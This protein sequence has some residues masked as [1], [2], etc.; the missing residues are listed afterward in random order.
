MNG[1][2]MPRQFDRIDDALKI[3]A[4]ARAVMIAI[5]EHWVHLQEVGIKPTEEEL[6][7][8]SHLVWHWRKAAQALNELLE[9]PIDHRLD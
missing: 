5:G 4:R 2:A 3:E 6:G 9:Q 1:S 8:H 7:L